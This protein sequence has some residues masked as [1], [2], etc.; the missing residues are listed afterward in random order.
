MSEEPAGFDGEVTVP[1]EG[2]APLTAHAGLGGMTV[3]PGVRS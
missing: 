1:V 2:E 3:Q